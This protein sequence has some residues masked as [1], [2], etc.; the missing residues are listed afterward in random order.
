MVA[1]LEIEKTVSKK[2]KWKK[3]WKLEGKIEVFVGIIALSLTIYFSNY[4]LTDPIF[5]CFVALWCFGKIFFRK[6]KWSLLLILGLFFLYRGLIGF[7][8]LPR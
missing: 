1:I 3:W 2:E 6:D 4:P 7:N 5:S 8:H